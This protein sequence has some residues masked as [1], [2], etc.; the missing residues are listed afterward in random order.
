MQRLCNLALH[1]GFG[2]IAGGI[3]LL[4]ELAWRGRTHWTM[5]PL[6]AVIF[7]CAGLLDEQ[8]NPP[9][10][11]AQV[12]IGTAIATALEFAA[13][14]IINTWLGL[15]VWDYSNLPGN[16]LGQICPQF[17]LAWA[18]LMVISIKLE[19]FMHRVIQAVPRFVR[20]ET[21]GRFLSRRKE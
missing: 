8:E 3:Y 1:C 7:V 15:G 2:L 21:T 10:F 16:L 19:N 11:W 5:L 14:L 17:T 6:A 20:K 13:G 4:I 18:A 9:P 12:I